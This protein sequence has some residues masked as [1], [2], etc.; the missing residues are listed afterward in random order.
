M[1]QFLIVKCSVGKP[2]AGDSLLSIIISRQA[3]QG[4]TQFTEL[5]SINLY[6]GGRVTNIGHTT[7]ALTGSISTNDASHISMSFSRPT[8][9]ETGLYACQANVL[10]ALG[11]PRTIVSDVLVQEEMTLLQQYAHTLQGLG[12]QIN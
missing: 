3:L 6:D 8:R 5:A 1:T 11:H 4:S 2:Q 9:N 10:D 7:A 12:D